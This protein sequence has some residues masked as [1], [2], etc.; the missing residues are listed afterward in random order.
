[1][2]T[3]CHRAA[4]AGLLLLTAGNALAGVLYVAVNSTSPAAPYTNWCTAAVIIQ[5]AVDAAAAGDE[6]VVTN[7][8]YATGG[9]AVGTNLLA[10]RV[11]LD[12]AVALRS[13]NGP[14]FT[15]I[16]G[17]W[18]PGTTNGPAAVRCAYLTNG[19]SDKQNILNY[20]IEITPPCACAASS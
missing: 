2:T 12:K 10:N 17:A 3:K 16:Q 11:A 14:A 8:V 15:V 7:G 19:A 20:E 5:E 1:M 13:V 4:A 6:I 9:R 18:E